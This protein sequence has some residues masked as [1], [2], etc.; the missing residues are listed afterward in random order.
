MKEA[1][2]DTATR[3]L[4]SPFQYRSKYDQVKYEFEDRGHV[5]ER[6]KYLNFYGNP[7][8]YIGFAFAWRVNLIDVA[9]RTNPQS[10]PMFSGI[11][12]MLHSSPSHIVPFAYE[13]SLRSKQPRW[14]TTPIGVSHHDLRCKIY[15]PTAEMHFA[16]LTFWEFVGLRSLQRRFSPA[17]CRAKTFGLNSASPQIPMSDAY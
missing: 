4:I 13:P 11:L 3:P 12:V 1:K 16:T 9:A 15:S 5:F 6:R 10:I 8:T 14:L 17:N 2:S 7:D